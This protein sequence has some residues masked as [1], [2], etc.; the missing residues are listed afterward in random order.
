MKNLLQLKEISANDL[1][2]K[3]KKEVDENKNLLAK[4]E[5][6]CLEVKSQKSEIESLRME[7]ESL[8]V[9]LKSSKKEIK[10]QT[11]SMG[12]KIEALE[13]TT[14]EL[15]RFKTNKMAEERE[16][17][18][19]KKKEIKKAKK[20]LSEQLKVEKEEKILAKE[21]PAVLDKNITVKKQASK[22]DEPKVEKLIHELND[23]VALE[24]HKK[25]E[26]DIENN[27]ELEQIGTEVK[28]FEENNEHEKVVVKVNDMSD[29]DFAEHLW[30]TFCGR[31]RPAKYS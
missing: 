6:K 16:E 22:D 18:V 25:D 24:H 12:V 31:P 1:E 14:A 11:K 27:F 21:T 7:K 15:S 8:S 20:K 19:R 2:T 23:A 9:A 30:K 3:I 4:F 13:K 26:S 28:G 10:E 17:R 29:E 5:T